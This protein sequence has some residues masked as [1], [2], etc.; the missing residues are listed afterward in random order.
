MLKLTNAQTSLNCETAHVVVVL[1][2][3]GTWFEVTTFEK[4]SLPEAT[5]RRKRNNVADSDSLFCE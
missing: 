2:S 1:G 3:T 5:V 4:D